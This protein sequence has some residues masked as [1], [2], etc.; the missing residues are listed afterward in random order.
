MIS[1]D[2]E[3]KPNMKVHIRGDLIKSQQYGVSIYPK[4]DY[5]K[6]TNVILKDI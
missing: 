5:F 6:N 1:K 4:N 2:I 3:L